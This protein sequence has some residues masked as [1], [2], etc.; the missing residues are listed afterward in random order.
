MPR[1]TRKRSLDLRVGYSDLKYGIL[2][3]PKAERK[4]FPGFK[5][6]F[7]LNR[8]NLGISEAHM[9]S[10]PRDAQIGDPYAG[11][12]ITGGLKEWYQKNNVREEDSVRVIESRRYKGYDLRKI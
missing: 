8:S 11:N 7:E 9:S 3:V 10:G 4:F 5:V 2:R 12:Y 1:N 6:P